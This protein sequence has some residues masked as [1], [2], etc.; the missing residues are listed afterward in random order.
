MDSREDIYDMIFKLVVIGD[1]GVGKT[2]IIN[3]YLHQTFSSDAKATVGVEFGTKKICVDGHFIK[4]QIWD[5]AGQER[6]R[7]I[8]NAYY[9]GAK[10]AVIVYDI[11]NRDS[12]VNVERWLKEIRTMGDVSIY[13]VLAGNK[14]DL[15]S[16]R[17]VSVEEGEE[18]SKSNSIA[19]LETSGLNAT[20]I[21]KMFDI[22]A[23][24]VY[25]LN[26]TDDADQ[27]DLD[28]KSNEQN[29]EISIKENK[30]KKCC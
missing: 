23:E 16:K 1:S 4:A 9:K 7:S 17:V 2:G 6:Y 19:F 29:I 15:Q 30:N 21:E 14:F 27:E 22:I 13:I 24:N 8:T 5:T 26:K 11:T 12:F 3:Q 28:Y 20:N 18:L 25:R 10:A